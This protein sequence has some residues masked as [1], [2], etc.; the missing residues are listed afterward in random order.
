M[1]SITYLFPLLVLRSSL[2]PTDPLPGIILPTGPPYRFS[3]G[4]IFDTHTM[5][6]MHDPETLN[7]NLINGDFDLLVIASGDKYWVHEETRKAMVRAKDTAVV[8]IM[9][10]TQVMGVE[11]D[12]LPG[13]AAEGRL[14]LLGLSE[15][16][17][18]LATAT[19]ANWSLEDN[20]IGWDK[21]L[22]ETFVPVSPIFSFFAHGSAGVEGSRS[23]SKELSGTGVGANDFSSSSWVRNYRCFPSRRPD[24]QQELLCTASRC[25]G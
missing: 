25:P 23:R 12:T 4:D 8:L 17:T 19:I 2:P 1:Q 6:D 14:S 13:I 18:G 16:T 3:F 11:R 15:H 24:R 9:H 10:H 21:V 7:A 22:T 5:G 20:E